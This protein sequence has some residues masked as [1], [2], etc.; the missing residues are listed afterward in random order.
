MYTRIL[1]GLDDSQVSSDA[2]AEAVRLARDQHAALNVVH[3]VDLHDL[4][5]CSEDIQGAYAAECRRCARG[6]DVLERARRRAIEAGVEAET[7]LLTAECERVSDALVDA[8][9]RWHADLIVA[10][11]HRRRGLSR[12]I[13]GSVAA[14]I[15]RRAPVAVLVVGG[16]GE[17]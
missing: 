17:R 13:L 12:L 10:G 1:V 16:E 15:A 11:T 7:T 3:V 6:R 8:C 4:Y 2:L 14:G 5:W 9:R